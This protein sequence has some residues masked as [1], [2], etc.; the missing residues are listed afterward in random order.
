M[1]ILLEDMAAVPVG[2]EPVY[3]NGEIVGNTTSAAYGF[4][5]DRPV[6]LAFID[7]NVAVD[8][9]GIGV[10]IDI[11]RKRHRIVQGRVQSR[12]NKNAARRTS[13]TRIIHEGFGCQGKSG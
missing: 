10:E 5:V 3:Y 7:P 12:R 11:A 13:L 4:R 9:E 8:L 1:C 6:A 2:N